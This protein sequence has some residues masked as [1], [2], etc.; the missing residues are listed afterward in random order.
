VATA[1]VA[2]VS[3]RLGGSDGVSVEAAKWAWALSELGFAIVTVAGGGPVDRL[4]PGLAIDAP[5]P[6]TA[7]ELDDALADAALV[8]VENL[9]SLPLNPGAL[10]LVAA[11]LAGRPALF[12][13]HDLPWQR[14]RFAGFPPPPDDGAW[15]HVATSRFSAGQLAERGI[16]AA[17]VHNAFDT[18]AAPGARARTRA[19]MEIDPGERVVV[20]PT[21]AIERKRVDLG[22]ALAAEADATFW[23]LG[24]AEDGF[25]PE[26]DR[27]L[28][29]AGTTRV[30]RG[31]GEGHGD[32]GP[33]PMADVYAA[34]DA[35]VLPSSW[36]GFGNPALESAVHRRPLAIGRY[37]VALELAEYGFRWVAAD[38]PGRFAS[39][40]GGADP[41]AAAHNFA[42]ADRHFALRDLP[43]RLAKVLAAAGWHRW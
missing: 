33:F 21:R 12:H 31:H 35:V 26:L 28:A 9:C 19:A 4:L 43:E 6:P 23:L 11:R 13:H 39:V 7:A 34:A 25:G 22:L 27:I 5:A 14:A 3:F 38:D 40:V 20:Q 29:G 30:L 10:E 16:D 15:S 24:P 17:V 42:V 32:G 41:D 18:A 1:T 37:P 2:I 8:V 36:E